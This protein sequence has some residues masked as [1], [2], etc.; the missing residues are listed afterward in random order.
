MNLIHGQKHAIGIPFFDFNTPKLECTF[1]NLNEKDQKKLEEIY[2]ETKGE[3]ILRCKEI[4]LEAISVHNSDDLNGRLLLYLFRLLGEFTP[5]YTVEDSLIYNISN[6]WYEDSDSGNYFNKYE[7]RGT[8]YMMNLMDECLSYAKTS[9]TATLINIERFCY[10]SQSEVIDMLKITP[11][12]YIAKYNEFKKEENPT[13]EMRIMGTYIEDKLKF[14]NA[15][16]KG[17]QNIS[18]EKLGQNEIEKTYKEIDQIFAPFEKKRSYYIAPGV[19][20]LSGKQNWITS[21]LAF[22]LKEKYKRYNLYGVSYNF[23]FINIGVNHDLNSNRREYFISPF[24]IK[25]KYFMLSAYRFGKHDSQLSS[26]G[27]GIFYRPEIGFHYGIFDISYSYNLTFNKEIRP[28]TE[29]HLLSVGLSYPL[30]RIGK[31]FN[32]WFDQ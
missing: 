20:Y 12:E 16:N 32:S 3:E 6:P 15:L 17:Q 8:L 23:N 1:C 26:F 21:E 13:P 25:T 2:L 27:K 28:L 5:D 30:I 14:Y 22:G 9:E 19:E 10:L 11:E 31:Y 29:K 24:E 18:F 4:I 7:I